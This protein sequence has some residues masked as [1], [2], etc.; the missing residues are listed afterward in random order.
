MI[1]TALFGQLMY[2]KMYKLT[3]NTV[4]LMLIV[5]NFLIVAFRSAISIADRKDSQSQH[6]ALLSGGGTIEG[7]NHESFYKNVE[8][9]YRTLKNLG[10]NDDNIKILFHGGK[11]N[12]HPIVEGD[13]TRKNFIY[14]LRHFGRKIGSEDS[15]IIF[16]SG[17]GILK[18][19]LNK[20]LDN[21][22]RQ[23]VVKMKCVGTKA[24]MRFPDGDLCQMEFKEILSEIN[25]KQIIVVL[26]QCFAG[27]FTD[28]ALRLD[29]TVIIT[30]TD[31]LE[32][33]VKIKRKTIRWNHDEWPFV[34][35]I[36]D[37][38]SKKDKKGEKQSVY[39]AYHYQLRCNPYVR[40]VPVHPDRP[41]LKTN[42][43]IKYGNKL[44]KGAVYLH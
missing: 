20:S 9:A 19:I 11:T 4:C 18:L 13:A 26:N 31:D 44:D 17:H 32:V 1:I 12:D 40:G 16:R 28:I 38:F 24:V 10:Y 36:L 5:G 27:K 39:S 33:A 14:E 37:G 21:E 35:C 25:G 8:Y 42:P 22:N 23:G 3:H 2:R 6:Y 15:L 43:K 30:E 41:L 7:D 29:N 34:K